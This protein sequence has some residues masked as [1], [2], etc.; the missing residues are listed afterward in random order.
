[1]GDGFNKW[2]TWKKVFPKFQPIPLFTLALKMVDNLI[3]LRSILHI[4]SLKAISSNILFSFGPLDQFVQIPEIFQFSTNGGNIL[5]IS[6]D[7]NK[8]QTIAIGTSSANPGNAPN[9]E[10][11]I[12]TI[13]ANSKQENDCLFCLRNAMLR[14]G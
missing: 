10:V 1:M 14:F 6:C 7:V 8:I 4:L 9:R 12:E 11:A 5:H 13:V 2:I 3:V